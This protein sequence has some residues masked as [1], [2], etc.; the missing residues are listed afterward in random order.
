MIIIK[1][2][3]DL[4]CDATDH[5]ERMKERSITKL[6]HDRIIATKKP[7]YSTVEVSLALARSNRVSVKRLRIQNPN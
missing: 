2:L 3:A 4:A 5:F 1:L 6:D 7:V